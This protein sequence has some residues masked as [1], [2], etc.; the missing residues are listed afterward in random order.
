MAS[1]EAECEIYDTASDE[2]ATTSSRNELTTNPLYESL[3][4]KPRR[5]LADHSTE[6]G[7][8]KKT[9]SR[10]G[11]LVT[12]IALCFF[13][14]ITACAFAIAS[15]VW[16]TNDI[17]K[18]SA[19]ATLPNE[20]RGQLR[21]INI[22]V[23]TK[24]KLTEQKSESEM[25]KLKEAE[26]IDE[27]ELKETREKLKDLEQRLEFLQRQQNL[28]ELE[29]HSLSKRP[30]A[31]VPISPRSGCV[32]SIKNKSFILQDGMKY[33]NGSL[34]V[35]VA[36]VYYVF[37]QVTLQGWPSFSRCLLQ[38]FVNDTVT[39]QASFWS[40]LFYAT[41]WTTAHTGFLINLSGNDYLTIKIK[42]SSACQNQRVWT[43]QEAYFG[44]FL[45]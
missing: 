43:L 30:L 15:F 8:G 4:T 38:V 17:V 23:Q 7:S 24:L 31:I 39:N 37:A 22:T 27:T 20:L 12:V 3:L 10:Y 2:T 34:V 32:H 9:T 5:T 45:V 42:G 29:I 11:S 14:S 41:T 16:N 40:R 19:M 21:K 25:L 26:Q 36:G 13:L 35:P 44:G 6:K 18:N 33:C 28:T 1:R